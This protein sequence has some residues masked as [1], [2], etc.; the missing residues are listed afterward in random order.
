M[1]YGYDSPDSFTRAFTKF[2]G[3]SPS[4]AKETGAELKAFAPLRIKLTLEGGT[5]IL[6]SYLLKIFKF[7]VGEVHSSPTNFYQKLK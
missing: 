5:P 6:T 1:K 3:I 4:A 7:T 2:H